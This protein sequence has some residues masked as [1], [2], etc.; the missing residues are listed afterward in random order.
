MVEFCSHHDYD[1]NYADTINLDRNNEVAKLAS[2]IY[3]NTLVSAPAL[4][5]QPGVESWSR[6]I[7]LF[8]ESGYP[9]QLD[10]ITNEPHSVLP[11][12]W[13]VAQGH[14]FYTTS[15]NAHEWLDGYYD[16]DL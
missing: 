15:P 7:P 2:H 1:G 11:L 5:P 9:K 6:P 16:D 14:P 13:Y 8:V 12:N 3:S 4:N 10:P